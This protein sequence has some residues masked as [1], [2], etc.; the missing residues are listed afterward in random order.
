MKTKDPVKFEDDSHTYTSPKTGEELQ[1]VT[2]FV[3]QFFEDFDADAVI[4]EWYEKWQEEEDDRYY[5][6]TRDEIK[7]Q[8]KENGL[9]KSKHGTQVHDAIEQFL[10]DNIDV[11][12]ILDSFDAESQKKILAATNYA[13]KQELLHSPVDIAPELQIYSD[14]HGLAGTIDLI[15]ERED[16]SVVLY[17][18]KTNDKI[19]TSG[20]WDAEKR[21]TKKA[22]P[23]IEEL[24]DCHLS[25]Y[26][27]QL[28]VYAYILEQEYGVD[29]EELNL[30]HLSP[31]VSVFS[32]DYRKDL[33]EKML[34]AAGGDE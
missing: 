19:K 3:G 11:I 31:S 30:V 8:W 17:D 15:F 10:L 5:G 20:F 1:S 29:V 2:E 6:L 34:E 7:A 24:D 28:S 13:N 14:Y 12:D 25:K 27:L 18:W 16:G 22:L 4:D 9:E 33:V 26:T 23:P 21:D 32:V